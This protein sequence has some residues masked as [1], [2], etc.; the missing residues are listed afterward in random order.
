[1]KKI[2]KIGL[3]LFLIGVV[4]ATGTYLYLFHKPHRNIAREKPA[5][6]MNAEDLYTEFSSD[7]TTSYEKYG[8]KVLQVTG[9]VVEFDL[10]SNGASLV[11]VDPMEGINCEFDSTTVADT[12]NELSKIDVGKIVT[13][14][15]QC[16][17]FDL[18][19]GVVLTRCVLIESTQSYTSLN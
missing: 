5:F 15:G 10:N 8:N 7:E 19:M 11:Y 9:K 6:E 14:K 4:S 12:R 13:L 17:G 3:I 2:I 16:D 18:I 1:M